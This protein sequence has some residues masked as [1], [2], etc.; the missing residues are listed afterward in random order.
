MKDVESP[1]GH[2]GASSLT[3]SSR[4]RN[5]LLM[6]VLPLAA[7]A[8]CLAQIVAPVAAH[9]QCRP[10]NDS[11]EAK[12]LAFHSVPL[13][14]TSD[15]ASLRMTPGTLRLSAEGAL[16]PRASTA[17]QRTSY[18]YSGKAENTG[19]APVFGRP[20]LSLG[21]PGGVGIEDSYLPAVT[22]ADATPNLASA[23]IWVTRSVSDVLALT[24]RAH[25]TAGTVL[26]P[27]TCPT[28][29]LQQSDASQPCYG[30]SPSRDEFRA[31]MAGADVVATGAPA[32]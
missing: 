27:I 13:A 19:L 22:I 18:R 28:R 17:L 6:A 10:P 5:T 20:R 23:A 7:A 21:L 30:K 14:F 8:A 3:V 32:A 26:G 12:L 31:D 16:V 9:A 25:G 29:S 24:L 1:P 15:F 11:N 2:R 4:M